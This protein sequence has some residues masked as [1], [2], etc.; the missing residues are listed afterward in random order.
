VGIGALPRDHPHSGKGVEVVNL[1]LF[2]H[3]HREGFR[4]GK[5][6]TEI[7]RVRALALEVQES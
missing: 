6:I 1:R 2:I 3:S 7:V 5:I 4:N